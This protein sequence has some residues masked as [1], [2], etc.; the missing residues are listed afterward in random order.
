HIITEDSET[1]PIALTVVAGD[2]IGFYY[3]AGGLGY[4]IT[5]YDGAWRV[6]GEYIDPNDEAEYTFSEGDAT[7]LIGYGDIEAPPV[8]QPYISR[9]QHIA[10]MRTMGV[11][12]VG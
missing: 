10:G 1:N 12:Q 4:D 3:T 6:S 11:N 5:G 9:V 2:Y 8:G 7:S